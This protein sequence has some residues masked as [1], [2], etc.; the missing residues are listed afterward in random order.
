MK[1]KFISII[2]ILLSLWSC[3]QSRTKEI[4][5]S[6]PLSVSFGDPYILAASDGRYYMYGTSG[7][8]GFRAYSSDDLTDWKEEGLVYQ[9]GTDQSWNVDCFWAPEVYERGLG[10][11]AKISKEYE[12]LLSIFEQEFDNTG[13][14]RFK[15]FHEGVLMKNIETSQGVISVLINKNKEKQTIELIGFEKYKP[16]R[17]L[18]QDKGGEIVSQNKV[19]I[20]PEETIVIDW[21]KK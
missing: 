17:M 11:G 15:K 21:R 5:Y 18:F 12:P 13:A 16:H 10:L 3:N 14:F 6:N 20:Y 8:K 19:Y 7:E 4:T 2:T 1:I 9:G